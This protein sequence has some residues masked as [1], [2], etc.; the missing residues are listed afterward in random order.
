MAPIWGKKFR[1]KIEI[2]STHSSLS[3]FL[4]ESKLQLP[5]PQLLTHD[6]SDAKN[7]SLAII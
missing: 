5:V 1:D 7:D 6:A 3:L 2:F 4:S